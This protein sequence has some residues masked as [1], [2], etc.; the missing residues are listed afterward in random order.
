MNIGGWEPLWLGPPSRRLYGA[1]HGAVGAATTTGVVLVPPLLHEQP[2]SRRFLTEVAGE[3]AA[4]GLPCLRFDFHGTG[5]STGTGEQLDFASMRQ[6][7][8]VAT[9]A[10]RDRA[11]IRRLALLAWRGSA[12][13]IHAWLQQGGQADLIVLWEPVA[14]GDALLRELVAGDAGERALRPPPRPGVARL[15]D[16]S[17]GQLMGFPASARLRADLAHAR[18]AGEEGGHWPCWTVVRADAAALPFEAARVLQLPPGAPA[19]SA[20]ASMDATCFLTP[21]VREFVG[22]LGQAL[23]SEAW[24]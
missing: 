11:G 3:L 16:P 19:F 7:L 21:P 15:T 9:D 4:L 5:D 2:C 14:D 13:P 17:D 18:L 8:D 10:L 22:R 23:R 1:F 6:D 12:L 24:A 20:S